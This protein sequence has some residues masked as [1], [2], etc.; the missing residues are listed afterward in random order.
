MILRTSAA[1]LAWMLASCMISAEECR[2]IPEDPPREPFFSGPV[3]RTPAI[4]N[5]A[6]LYDISAVGPLCCAVGDRGV[7]VRSKDAGR[8]W[9]TALLPFDCSLRSVSFLTGKIG[10]TAG[11]RLDPFT[12]IS[13]G[14]L[15]R[16]RDG[17]DTWQHLLPDAP[18]Q[19]LPG[20]RYVKFFDLDNGAIV[21]QPQSGAAGSLRFTEDRGRSWHVVPSDVPTTDW[22]HAVFLKPEDG[23]LVGTGMAWGSI[24]AGR[25]VTLAPPSASLQSVRGV[26]L[27]SDGRAWIVGDGGVVMK[28]ENG[29]ISW[30]EPDGALPR[31]FR[32]VFQLNSVVHN[33]ENVCIVG[34]P[35]TAVLRSEDAG[36]T[37]TR[38]RCAKN[39][40]IHCLIRVEGTTLLAAG[41]WG[42]IMRSTDFG[43]TWTPVR[44]GVS[45]AALLCL[46]TEPKYA[47][48]TML[49]FVAG[50]A[51]YRTVLVQPS[52][53]QPV[54]TTTSEVY[55]TGLTHLGT[56]TLVRDWRFPRTV[57]GQELSVRS[58]M[59][60]WNHNSDGRL[61]DLLPLRLAVQ[62]RMWQ[63]DVICI[64]A[65]HDQDAVAE[66]WR[67]AIHSAG[68]IA[69]GRDARAQ[70]LNHTGL[71]PWSIKRIVRR[72][73][74][75]RTT[76]TCSANDLL[77]SLATTAGLLA[78]WWHQVVGW[79]HSAG[80]DEAS[81]EIVTLGRSSVAN[82][83]SL[84][85]GIP[86]AP[87]T[88][89][90]RPQSSRQTDKLQLNEILARHHAQQAALTGL[91]D[92]DPGSQS[93]I[94]ELRTL[95][96]G[97]PVRL[98][99]AQLQ[100]VAQKHRD[101]D[102]LGGL[103][104]VLQEILRRMSD[105]PQ[106]ASAAEEL[107]LLYSSQ[108]LRLLRLRA[109]RSAPALHDGELAPGFEPAH[110][111][112][113]GLPKIRMVSGVSLAGWVPHAGSGPEALERRWDEQ[114]ETAW[115]QL[116]RISARRA[117]DARNLL[118]RAARIRRSGQFGADRS[119][120]AEVAR[121]QGRFADLARVE[122]Q[123]LFSAVK[124]PVPVFNLPKAVQRPLLD[125]VLSDECWQDAPEIRLAAATSA[126]GDRDSL[127]MISWDKEFVYLG[128]R[129]EKADGVEIPKEALNRTHDEATHISDRME[130]FFDI[131]R[132]Y[133]SGWSLTI[134]SA[135]R[136]ADRCH[137]FRSWDPQ[138]FV[139]TARDDS[140]WRFEAAVPVRELLDR[141]LKAGTL[142]N[143]GL[144]RLAPGF[145]D[146]QPAETLHTP[147]VFDSRDTRYSLLR[148]I[149]NRKVQAP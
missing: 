70:V 86:L 100:H 96:T 35:A 112:L 88:D 89:A 121:G 43:N 145:T 44:N 80:S 74:G 130:F 19:I 42:R 99:A 20:L 57:A 38:R 71:V 140:H 94:G 116:S 15:L 144:R 75:R 41:V 119:I 61:R 92:A 13:Q 138:W 78:H 24:V 60:I 2:V 49:A 108:E 122:S 58:L 147:G 111:E 125:G 14:V 135:G 126:H 30:A 123:A 18:G 132:D 134:D 21:T 40:S 115:N 39:G 149:R 128:G 69:N 113:L 146:Q 101:A 46:V 120:L 117:Q 85:Q 105:S 68:R 34:S 12:G 53:R 33:Q 51:G 95:G 129:I 66:I 87:G 148:F 47:A 142:W 31:E 56:G 107:H 72:V 3:P 10:Y 63:P 79:E 4:A 109:R 55:H 8:T 91:I 110:H 124:T 28:S 27:T 98:A 102:N 103:T 59:E 76:L 118:V 106:A 83:S 7:I 9:T 136:T 73:P 67:S 45:R 5:D 11:Y 139:A 26:S 127:V 65:E 6:S 32:D 104:A 137:T 25:V 82:P 17:G 84:F 1:A 54:D 64:E 81:W 36:R 22:M 23:L 143:V 48:A 29:G 90:R 97:L 77:P 141:P 131:D 93:L 50:D 62:I 37:W 52:Q 114:A 16:T 133:S